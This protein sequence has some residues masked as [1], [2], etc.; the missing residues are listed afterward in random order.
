M[1]KIKMGGRLI[2]CYLCCFECGLI[3]EGKAAVADEG[4]DGEGENLVVR[5]TDK[6][7]N[8]KRFPMLGQ[9]TKNAT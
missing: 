1:K 3:G 4:G 5:K 9:S 8:G 6:K 7:L 2:G